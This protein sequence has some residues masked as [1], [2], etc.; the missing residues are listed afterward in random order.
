MDSADLVG[1][2]FGS[3]G[4][5]PDIPALRMKIQREKMLVDSQLQTGIQA[6]VGILNKG[7]QDLTKARQDVETAQSIFSEMHQSHEESAEAVSDFAKIQKL[8]TVVA[9]FDQTCRFMD[10][11]SSF[12]SDISA[13]KK[14]MSAD[15][16]FEIESRMPNLLKTHYAITQIRNVQD[17]AQRFLL[18]HEA[19]SDTRAIVRKHFEPL[20]KLVEVFDETLFD[21]AGCLLEIL[22]TGDSSLV[23]RVAKI[24]DYEEKRDL[25]VKM[26]S[27]LE[28]VQ[29][30]H[31][32]QRFFGAVESS[33]KDIFKNL[34]AEY[35]PMNMPEELLENL[36]W[37][38]SDLSAARQLL[39]PCVPERWKVFDKYVSFYHQAMH[40]LLETIMKYEPSAATLLV[41]LQF[42]KKYYATMRENFGLTKKALQP[43]L[44]DGREKEYYED[45]LKMLVSKLKEWYK[46]IAVE[47]QRPFRMRSS[48][49]EIHHDGSLGLEGHTT[50]S[51]LVSQQLEVAANSSQGRVV[52]GCVDACCEILMQRQQEWINV[53]HEEVNRE[54]SP[55]EGDEAPPGLFE[56]LMA[57]ANDQDRSYLFLED[58]SAKWSEPLP[59]KYKQQV[60]QRFEEAQQG[61]QEVTKTCVVGI[62]RIIF[63]DCAKAFDKIFV[64][65][66]W[67]K[68]TTSQEIVDTLA[69]FVSEAQAALIPD[70]F[71]IFT[72]RLCAETVLHYLK[73]TT[74][75]R[76]KLSM[77][78]G[79]ERILQDVQLFY[80][81]FTKEDIS[82][83][84]GDIDEL[85]S[86]FGPFCDALEVPVSRLADPFEA[87]RD[88]IWDAPVDLYECM[89]G[90][91]K[92]VDKSAFKATMARV[93]AFAVQ[94][95][96]GSEQ[97]HTF[98]HEFRR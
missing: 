22:R 73:A 77:P 27:K 68:G 17:E 24:V 88:K 42:V 59:S 18:Q 69:D 60:Q 4:K 50:V 72:Y 33:V 34:M 94:S 65:S 45:Y 61:Y 23:V 64:D 52:A 66:R 92:D 19:T 47:E 37:V 82:A 39:Q 54:T 89:I 74:H 79:K 70:L 30:R 40:D 63:A 16:P 36:D 5:I 93:R 44:L 83:D 97:E 95:Q 49:P 96:G 2:L 32:P 67:L 8:F 58:L 3:K 53:V 75:A 86:V 10:H 91:R 6:Q 55:V 21:I 14:L 62:L 43:P 29:P 20:D 56:Y 13:L 57:L 76:G 48:P 9:N 85:F 51:K 81:F 84:P 35:S 25:V 98:L 41:L 1:Q 28:G 31:Y 7:M 78:K 38:Y 15:G 80:G 90:I 12:S 11:F 87:L 26:S 46:T 71:D